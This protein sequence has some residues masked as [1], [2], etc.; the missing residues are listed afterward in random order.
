MH[1]KKTRKDL[2]SMLRGMDLVNS[3][4]PTMPSIYSCLAQ[5]MHFRAREITIGSQAYVW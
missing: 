1:L 3:Y 2:V 5:L 4:E